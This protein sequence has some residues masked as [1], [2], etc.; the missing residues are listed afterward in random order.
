[1]DRIERWIRQKLDAA[2]AAGIGA[3][4]DSAATDLGRPI[5]RFADGTTTLTLAERGFRCTAP[6]A[7][8]EHRYDAIKALE[9]APLRTIMT[10]RGDPGAPVTIGLILRD[11]PDRA[12]MQWPLGLY[13]N[14]VTVLDRIVRDLA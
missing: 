9:L 2:V 12:E 5:Y 13:A 7:A 4:S 6:G 10:L 1:M 8:L 14:V 3:W 11:S